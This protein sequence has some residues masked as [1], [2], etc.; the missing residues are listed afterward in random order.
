[1]SAKDRPVTMTT[2]SSIK[3]RILKNKRHIIELWEKR[4][5]KEVLSARDTTTIILKHSFED[6]LEQLAT[7]LSK[8]TEKSKAQ[9]TEE[10]RNRSEIFVR[11]GVLRAGNVGYFL[12]EVIFEFHILRQVLFEVLENDV[13]LNRTERDIILDS[14]EQAVNDAASGFSDTLKD[15]QEHFAVTLT[16]DLRGPLT[17]SKAAAQLILRRPDYPEQV[18]KWAFHIVES[19]D[20]LDQMIRDILN[21]S[22]LRAGEKLPIEL[23]VFDM[24]ALV[25]DITSEFRLADPE[26]FII[27]ASVGVMGSWSYEG[28]RRVLQNLLSNAV[29]YASPTSPITV[30][31]EEMTDKVR[32]T[33]HNNGNPIPQEKQESLF[34]PFRQ[35]KSTESKPGWGI[36][37]FLARGIV[38][39]HGGNIQLVSS[40]DEG[41]SFVVEL[42]KAV[43]L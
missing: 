15:I 5:R 20:R 19:Q 28:V 33:V 29:K 30:K 14:I 35:L 27:Q 4:A 39:A 37:L 2:Q 13:P 40:E 3:E 41:T 42:P 38:E 8:P 9:L 1:M 18:E 21:A 26:R 10:F 43:K 36:G 11:H 22:K 32:L 6:F 34:G 16:H 25:R 23:S 17:A 24:G 12:H 31:L 7:A